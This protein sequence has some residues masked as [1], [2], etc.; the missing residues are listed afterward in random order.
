V[1][2]LI[3]PPKG[4]GMIERESVMPIKSKYVFIASMD[5]EPDKEAIFNE[6]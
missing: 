5:V 4:G 6:V 1:R 3:P 2:R